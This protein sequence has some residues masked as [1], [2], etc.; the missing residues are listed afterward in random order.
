MEIGADTE[1]VLREVLGIESGEIDLL[2]SEHVIGVEQSNGFPVEP[3]R[4]SNGRERAS[5][6]RSV[7]TG[8]D[9]GEDNAKQGKLGS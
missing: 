9:R 8:R 5:E 4:R 6:G 7:V 3:G 2:R 1:S